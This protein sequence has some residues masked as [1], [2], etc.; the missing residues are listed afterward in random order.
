MSN[1]KQ[2]PMPLPPP[3]DRPAAGASA[4]H[5]ETPKVFARKNQDLLVIAV[6]GGATLREAAVFAKVSYETAKR[7][8][9]SPEF[10]KAVRRRRRKLEDQSQGML[11]QSL[12]RGSRELF[13]LLKHSD[14][15]VRLGA[16]RAVMKWGINAAEI[17]KI[18][19]TLEKMADRMGQHEV[20]ETRITPVEEKQLAYQR[21][22]LA[23]LEAEKRQR[24]ADGPLPTPPPAP[25]MPRTAFLTQPTADPPAATRQQTPREPPENPIPERIRPK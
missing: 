6:A 4:R 1:P 7:A 12:K 17:A 15:A 19:R 16:V 8:A 13:K 5:Q 22:F 2:N 9:R 20:T 14:P 23:K 10:R 21:D 3:S 18:E 11:I 25:A 24:E